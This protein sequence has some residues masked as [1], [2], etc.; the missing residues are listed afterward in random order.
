[1]SEG[2]GLRVPSTW[3]IRFRAV[4]GWA[5]A[6]GDRLKPFICQRNRAADPASFWIARSAWK[7]TSASSAPICTHRSPL[8]RALSRRSEEKSGSGSRATGRCFSSP[9]RAKKLWPNPKVT[10]SE[11]GPASRATSVSPAPAGSPAISRRAVSD[12]RRS[13]AA[14]SFR[15][16]PGARSKATRWPRACIGVMMPG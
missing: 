5:V 6:P 9:V 7:A 12:Q 11:D 3:P 14:A 8:L 2:L 16:A 1:M 10:V 13:S 15:P 4:I